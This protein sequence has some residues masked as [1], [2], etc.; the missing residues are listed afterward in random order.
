MAEEFFVP[1]GT[2]EDQVIRD[3]MTVAFLEGGDCAFTAYQMGVSE[4]DKKI[5]VDAECDWYVG[6]ALPNVLAA[7]RAVRSAHAAGTEES[8]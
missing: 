7:L 4:D 3:A 2:T 5:S 6:R 1:P 8:K